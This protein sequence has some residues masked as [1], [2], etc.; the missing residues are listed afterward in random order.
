MVLKFWNYKIF[1]LLLVCFSSIADYVTAMPTYFNSPVCGNRVTSMGGAYTAVSDDAAG[2]CYN[3]AGL[4]YALTTKGTDSSTSYV[5]ASK[6][7]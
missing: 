2:L 3:P 6:R 1:F 7:I 5:Q 4:A